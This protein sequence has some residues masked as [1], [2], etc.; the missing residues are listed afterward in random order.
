MFYY[1]PL[2][3][4]VR[5]LGALG[6]LSLPRSL[7]YDNICLRHTGLSQQDPQSFSDWPSPI[8]R[9]SPAR[10]FPTSSFFSKQQYIVRLLYH[11][12]FEWTTRSLFLGGSVLPPFFISSLDATS[13]FLLDASS[14][15]FSGLHTFSSSFRPLL[16]C[17][18]SL[19]MIWRQD[20]NMGIGTMGHDVVDVESGW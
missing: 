13:F 8:L 10:H 5:L 1:K 12:G 7:C 20:A 4:I 17:Y 18:S 14:L 3:R 16:S 11:N 2:S 9:A 15:V 19:A 6:Q